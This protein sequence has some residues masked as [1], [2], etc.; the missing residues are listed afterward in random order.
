MEIAVI[1]NRS[2]QAEVYKADNLSV[3]DAGCLMLWRLDESRELQLWRSYS[4]REWVTAWTIGATSVKK[5]EPSLSVEHV[6]EGANLGAFVDIHFKHRDI[7]CVVATKS[8]WRIMESARPISLLHRSLPEPPQ[9]YDQPM[10]VF[11]TDEDAIRKAASCVSEGKR[12]LLIL[13]S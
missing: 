2:S 1:S 9:F 10:D 4:S 5:T 8:V 3:N 12:C 11:E 13:K 6:M 7:D